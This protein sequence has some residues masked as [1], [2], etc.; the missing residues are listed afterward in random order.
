LAEPGDARD[1]ILM[2]SLS[3]HE[4]LTT[5]QFQPLIFIQHLDVVLLR[6]FQ[7]CTRAGPRHATQIV[8]PGEREPKVCAREGDPL[9]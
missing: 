8:I 3:K 1:L 4:N 9:Y 2:L 6:I 5:N 7:L